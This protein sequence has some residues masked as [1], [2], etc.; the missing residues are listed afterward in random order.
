MKVIPKW[1]QIVGILIML[2]LTL[3]LWNMGRLVKRIHEIE[4][5]KGMDH[6]IFLDTKVVQLSREWGCRICIR[7]YD[8]G[9]ANHRIMLTITKPYS[10]LAYVFSD[11]T[12]LIFIGLKDGLI[13]CVFCV[14]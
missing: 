13:S 11:Y 9:T 10:L 14:K 3:D 12:N 8:Y 6:D 2:A 4:K 1:I 7:E 5:C